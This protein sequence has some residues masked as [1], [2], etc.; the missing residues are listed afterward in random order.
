MYRPTVSLSVCLTVSVCLS[1]YFL[2]LCLSVSVSLSFLSLCLSVSVSLFTFSLSLSF[3]VCLSQSSMSF[4]SDPTG[5]ACAWTRVEEGPPAFSGGTVSRIPLLRMSFRTFQD[6]LGL[7]A[8]DF[9]LRRLSKWA[10]VSILSP[11]ASSV[12]ILLVFL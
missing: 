8:V 5:L 2:S 7:P 12:K 6:S 4:S 1:L 10:H 9:Y 11:W 3:S